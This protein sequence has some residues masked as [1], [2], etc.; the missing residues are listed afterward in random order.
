[1]VHSLISDPEGGFL[2]RLIVFRH[3]VQSRHEPGDRC[4]LGCSTGRLTLQPSEF[5]RHPSP[6][7]TQV[8]RITSS[9]RLLT[10]SPCFHRL[11][12]LKLFSILCRTSCS[13]IPLPGWT[14][15]PGTSGATFCCYST[16]L[17]EHQVLKV[18]D[19]FLSQ[20][21]RFLIK[22]DLRFH[23]WWSSPS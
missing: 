4:G 8:Y 2:T 6:P 23:R 20:Y 22:M 1:M 21:S 13:W 3:L 18:P 19:H 17:I 5:K 11:N 9:S 12:R 10:T 16:F 7:P 14:A 15:G